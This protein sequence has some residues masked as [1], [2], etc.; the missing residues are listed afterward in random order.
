MLLWNISREKLSRWET[1]QLIKRL[2]PLHRISGSKWDKSWISH[3][4][5]VVKI[6]MC[7]IR[8]PFWIWSFHS[9]NGLTYF[10]EI[11]V[12]FLPL[13]Y[14]MPLHSF[15]ILLLLAPQVLS[16]EPWVGS[17][18]PTIFRR[19]NLCFITL[20]CWSNLQMSIFEHRIY[21]ATVNIF[22]F[23]ADINALLSLEK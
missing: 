19:F 20:S 21:V 14:L 9:F 22:F 6:W 3:S 18:S 10:E 13:I 16:L 11:W 2:E 8:D 1:I 23:Q 5:M 12:I 15:Q 4:K 7:Y 17:G